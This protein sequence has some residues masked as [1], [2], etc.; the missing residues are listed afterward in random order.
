MGGLVHVTRYVEIQALTE[1]GCIFSNGQFFDGFI[2]R[3]LSKAQ[4]RA[5]RQGYTEFGEGMKARAEAKD[6]AA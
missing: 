2:A 5:I 1:T 3:F 6:Q 4:R